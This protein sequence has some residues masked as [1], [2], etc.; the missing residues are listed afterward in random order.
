MVGFA[1]KL[2]FEDE[3][4]R[5][6]RQYIPAVEKGRLRDAHRAFIARNASRPGKVR[7]EL[8]IQLRRYDLSNIGGMQARFNREDK[9]LTE[10]KLLEIER[11]VLGDQDN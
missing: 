11:K 9:A 5:I 8:L 7:H 4:R 3:S 6:L 10:D 1:T 2:E